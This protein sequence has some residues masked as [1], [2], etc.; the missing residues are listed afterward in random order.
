MCWLS[1][2]SLL[3]TRAH[4]KARCLSGRLGGARHNGSLWEGVKIRRVKWSPHGS[5]TPS[6]LTASMQMCSVRIQKDPER[7]EAAQSKRSQ[8]LKDLTL[9]QNFH[10]TS[11]HKCPLPFLCSIAPVNTLRSGAQITVTATLRTSFGDSAQP[12]KE[13]AS[14]METCTRFNL[15]THLIH[16][17]FYHA[18]SQK[19]LTVFFLGG[20][21]VQKQISLYWIYFKWTH[22]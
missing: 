4:S 11:L 21:G 2:P 10:L 20:V 5:Q 9:K 7:T 15:I 8:P 16:L 1:T 13:T 14:S 12:S 19:A 3:D 18:S 17:H 6:P 22:C